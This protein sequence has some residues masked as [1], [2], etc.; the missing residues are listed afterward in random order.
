MFIPNSLLVLVIT[1]AAVPL[2]TAMPNA[3]TCAQIGTWLDPDNGKP[4][5]VREL[6]ASMAERQVVLLGES[7]TEP[8]QHRWQLH[9]LAGLHALHPELVVGFEMFPRSVQPVLDDWWHGEL[10]ESEFLQAARWAQVWGYPADLY[11]PLLHF[12]RLQRLPMVAL[13]VERSLV[14]RVAESGWAEIPKRDREGLSDPAPATPDYRQF[15]A[16][17]YLEKQK[18]MAA[19]ELSEADS[20][21][22][23]Q[24]NADMASL[25][26]TED[27]AHFVEAQLTW[28]RAMAEA[29]AS[30]AR[31]H[32]DALVVGIIGRG[33]LMHGY[34]VPHQLT[35]LGIDAV[36]V[37]ETV[38]VDTVCRQPGV[39]AGLADAVFVINAE[40]PAARTP[41]GPMLGVAIEDVEGGVR[42][43]DILPGSVA[44]ATEL[45]VGDVIRSAAGFPVQRTSDLI[46]IIRR[47]AP[48]TWLPLEIERDG[49]TINPVARFPSHFQKSE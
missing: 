36:S 3:P 29:L 27:F 40:E 19:G 46:E 45:A 7:H 22:A 44:E 47:Q 41:A 37:L 35:D 4:I 2:V 49:G 31:R 1:L 24:D 6:M 23:D 20:T 33:H 5:P 43:L 16:Q 34:G 38:D 10:P 42:V 9:T 28:D 18:H 25:M 8:D 26:R 32:P 48:G 39:P 12:V 11:L 21:A 17:V 30:A 14:S 15:L 13:N